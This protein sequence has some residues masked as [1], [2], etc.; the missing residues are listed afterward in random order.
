MRAGDVMTKDVVA[1]SPDVEAREVA[2]VLLEHRI[3]AVPVVDRDGVPLG[4]VSEGDLIGRN[5]ADRQARRDWWLALLADGEALHPD[6]LASLR[7]PTRRASEVM[8]SPVVTVTEATDAVDVARM[9]IEHRIKRVPV[10]RD[11]RIVGIVSRGDLL[12][13]LAAHAEPRDGDQVPE[14]R[15]LFADFF[16]AIDGRF[17][18]LRDAA[19]RSAPSGTPPTAA[20]APAAPAETGVSADDFRGLADD[21][22][23]HEAERQQQQRRAV[24][25]QRRGRVKELID[26]HIRDDN[27]RTM[28]H[29]AREAAEH[30]AK[31]FMLLRFPA[32]LCT[33]RGR[34][35]NA[36]APYWP[37]TLRGEA[38]EIYQRWERELKPR[39]F[40]LSARVLDFPGGFPGDVGLFL[41][42]GE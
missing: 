10:V 37:E 13:A 30:G 8:S 28:L 40:R 12:R 19:A 15:G 22:E 23:H 35:I 4:M 24:E 32:E 25:A 3:S 16:T 36:P 11:G 20:E 1:V 14:R 9:L 33:D 31:E 34:A 6:F 7:N 2:K 29:A 26:E 27:W 39:G 18:H 5:D 38:A 42:W 17:G 41:V 21:F